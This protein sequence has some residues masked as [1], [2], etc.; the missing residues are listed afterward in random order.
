MRLSSL[1]ASG[2][3]DLVLTVI[4]NH[5]HSRRACSA[6]SS[7]VLLLTGLLIVFVFLRPRSKQGVLPPGPKPFPLV[8]NVFD[9]TS[10][11]LWLGATKWGKC[12]GEYLAPEL[13]SPYVRKDM[14]TLTHA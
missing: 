9:L 5:P 8:G 2:H 4:T 1:K 3:S 10:R 14:L 6:M 7:A 13:C 11:E 12:F